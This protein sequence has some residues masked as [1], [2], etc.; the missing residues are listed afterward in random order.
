MLDIL[1][2]VLAVVCMF[3]IE[4][5]VR[6]VLAGNSL[7]CVVRDVLDYV[8]VTAESVI[9]LLFIIGMILMPI[10]LLVWIF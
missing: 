8:S 1:I 6:H 9:P 2:V 5:A 7:L 3:F 10:L 4:L